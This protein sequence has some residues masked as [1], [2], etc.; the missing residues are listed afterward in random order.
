MADFIR[1]GH[2]E[3]HIRKMRNL[4][5][6]KRKL[7]IEALKTHFKGSAIVLGDAAGINVVVRIPS[8]LNDDEIVLRAKAAGIGIS[9]TAH[10]YLREPPRGEFQINYAHLKEEAIDSCIQILSEIAGQ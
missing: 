5:E 3:R 7:V 6:E 8:A 2:L 10:C 9:S 4:Y 1:L